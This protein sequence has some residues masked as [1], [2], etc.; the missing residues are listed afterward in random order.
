MQ[1]RLVSALYKK[2]LA[3]CSCGGIIYLHNSFSAF[4]FDVLICLNARTPLQVKLFINISSRS[5]ILF[6]WNYF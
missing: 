2:K 4:Y 1:S 6:M 3:T 5:V